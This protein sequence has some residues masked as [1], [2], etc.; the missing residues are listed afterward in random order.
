MVNSKTETL[1]THPLR[2]GISQLDYA[3]RAG[4][5]PAFRRF[6]NLFVGQDNDLFHNHEA[7]G[8][9][10][11]RYPL[12]QYKSLD[13]K[14]TLVGLADAGVGALN[15]LLEHPEFRERCIEWIG[16]QFAV[17]EQITDTLL[18][19]TA[20]VHNYRL[21]NYIALNEKNLADWQNNQSLPARSALLERCIVGH[22][23]KFCSAIQ[24]LLPP[25]SLQVELLDY[26]SHKTT[27]FDNPFLAFDVLFRTN[28]TLPE[29]IGLG[30]AVSHG[31]GT[32][33]SD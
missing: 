33:M 26:R 8:K 21:Q 32:V 31:F 28:I 14:A 17:T 11:Y 7:P 16:E 19:N 4:E 15:A 10:R 2:F 18:L 13:R 24:W 20:P 27:A 22:I 29:H 9:Y 23:L 6:V 12:V 1:S 3:L 5:V 25:K 30:K